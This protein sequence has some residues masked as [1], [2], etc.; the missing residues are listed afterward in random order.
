MIEY[1]RLLLADESRTAA[2]REAIGRVVRPGDVVVDLGCGSGVLS[3]FACEAGAARVYAIDSGHMADVASAMTRHLRLEDRVTVLHEESTRVRLPERANVLVTETMGA[4][5]LD[6]Q[7]L[8]YV[9][10]A[11][12]RL[13]ADDARI[14]P[15]RLEVF[16]AP[17]SYGAM[18]DQLV[19]W[20]SEPRYGIDWSP[21]RAFAASSLAH[22]RLE[23]TALL[24]DAVR[25]FDVDLRTFTDPFHT[26]DV[27]FR[28]NQP[29]TVHGFALWFVATLAPGVSFDSLLRDGASWR[30]TFFPLNVPLDAAVGDE[31]RLAI[32]TNNGSIW[33]WRGA[34]GS[35][36]F[37]Q[38]TLFAAP[39]CNLAGRPAT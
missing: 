24:A 38:S 27:T 30:Q 1:H 10:D 16:A 15:G 35:A 17:V 32:E 31:I 23:K 4:T 36:T 9:L 7:M 33:R 18:H 21:L 3:F 20:W 2:Y 12:G 14:I 29:G 22:I 6:E 37:D 5:G 26:S 28:A 19:G 13:L 11:R 8:G 25:V 34:I 39:P